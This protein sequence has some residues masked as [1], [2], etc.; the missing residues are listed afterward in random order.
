MPPPRRRPPPTSGCTSRRC[1]RGR[2]R[3]CAWQ[4]AVRPARTRQP[5]TASG[6]GSGRR[7]RSAC[8]LAPTRC[9]RRVG[10]PSGELL[11]F[12]G[13][14]RAVAG[15]RLA[16]LGCM[17]RQRR[18]SL[19]LCC[20]SPLAGPALDPAAW[21]TDP[22]ACSP[23]FEPLTGQASP[24]VSP[25]HPLFPGAAGGCRRR[26]V[27]GPVLQLLRGTGRYRVHRGGGGAGGHRAR[28]D[29]PGGGA[30]GHPW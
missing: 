25:P 4:C 13:S 24:A 26:P 10:S 30:R 11:L 23:A 29:A 7:W 5:R 12:C 1:R 22:S 6:C 18:L 8:Q 17:Q 19:Q 16:A 9:A 21:A 15:V 28:G 3:R 20:C 2:S 14:R 27:R